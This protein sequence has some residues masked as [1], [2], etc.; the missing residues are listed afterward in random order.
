MGWLARLKVF[1]SVYKVY[2]GQKK[3]GNR[4]SQKGDLATEASTWLS[5][6]ITTS[7]NEEKFQ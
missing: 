3:G 1:T 2:T 5:T 7:T 6:Y 4:S